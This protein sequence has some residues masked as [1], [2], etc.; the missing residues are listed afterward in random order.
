ML[1][2]CN[3]Q[4]RTEAHAAAVARALRGP[5]VFALHGPLGAGKTTWVRAFLRTLGHE[6]V[7]PSPTYTLVEPYEVGGFRIWHVDLYRL[8]DP[9]EMEGLGIRELLD[10]KAVML[11]EWPDRCPEISVLA[12]VHLHFRHGDAESAREVRWEGAGE[13]G[14]ELLRRA[15]FRELQG[16]SES[17]IIG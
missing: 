1:F 14:Q 3:R 16:K 13:R 7:V 17:N 5:C 8:E 10:G 15:D 6:G 9:L 12:D 4:D 2:E 11:V